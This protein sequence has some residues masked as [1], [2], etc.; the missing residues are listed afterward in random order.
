MTESVGKVSFEQEQLRLVSGY[1]DIFVGIAC[2]ITFVSLTTLIS[3]KYLDQLLVLV[4]ALG[5]AWYFVRHQRM[6][7]T[8]I[9]ISI[10]IAISGLI[11]GFRLFV[12]DSFHDVPPLPSDLG[13]HV[14]TLPIMLPL[15]VPLVITAILS[16]GFWRFAR[17]PLAHALG[18]FAI[19]LAILVGVIGTQLQL[20]AIDG[21]LNEMEP[22]TFVD[23]WAAFSKP[24]R[25]GGTC[26]TRNDNRCRPMS[27][28]GLISS[29]LPS[30]FS[31]SIGG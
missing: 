8:G 31:H 26:A 2:I 14:M 7:F 27:H 28:S 25:S 11:L 24:M 1:N 21:L 9:V 18:C 4:S 20:Q 15:I 5:L 22:S 16:I 23:P 3:E 30:S 12:I 10:A 13:E 6:R 17:V 29:L 19:L